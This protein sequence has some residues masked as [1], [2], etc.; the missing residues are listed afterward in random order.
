M[1]I[2]DYI[3]I[4]DYFL[5]YLIIDWWLFSYWWHYWLFID[6]LA[7]DYAIIAIPLLLLLIMILIYTDDAIFDLHWLLPRLIDWCHYSD[8]QPRRH[9]LTF[10]AWWCWLFSPPLLAAVGCWWYSLPLIIDWYFDDWLLMMIF[11][12]FYFLNKGHADDFL[13]WLF[14]YFIR[15]LSFRCFQAARHAFHYCHLA[16]DDFRFDCR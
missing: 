2:I 1:M 8:S 3:D 6:Y 5:I 16:F 9:W 10:S 12:I 13:F 14:H 4:I 7:I 11:S 15:F